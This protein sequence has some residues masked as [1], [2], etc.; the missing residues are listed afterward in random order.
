MLP[1]VSR[2]RRTLNNPAGC[3]MLFVETVGGLG[4]RDVLDTSRSHVYVLDVVDVQ[5]RRSR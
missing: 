2:G 5:E 1:N 4:I 3:D